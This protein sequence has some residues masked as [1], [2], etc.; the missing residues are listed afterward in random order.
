MAGLDTTPTRAGYLVFVR[1]MMGV[2]VDVLPDNSDYV[3]VSY[4]IALEIVNVGLKTI[5]PREYTRAVYNLGGSTL[6]NIAQDAGGAAPIAGTQPPLAYFAY[7]RSKF[8]M[9]GFVS[10]VI[11]SAG[12]EGTNESMVVQEAAKNFTLANLQQLKDPYGRAYLSIAQSYGDVW[13]VS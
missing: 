3:D 4:E 10:G 7:A 13:G 6:L 9:N 8:N 12:D 5:A 1:T 11:Q 2:P